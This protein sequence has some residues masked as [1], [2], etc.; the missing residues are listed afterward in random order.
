MRRILL[1]AAA[2]IGL[3]I[4]IVVIVVGY[5]YFNLNSII[6]SNRARLLAKASDAIGR[7]IEGRLLL[8]S[9]G[10]TRPEV[11]TTVNSV[12]P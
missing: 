5:A 9:S 3:I 10:A 11:A 12:G 8:P 4:L 7:P 6:A 1:A 2:L